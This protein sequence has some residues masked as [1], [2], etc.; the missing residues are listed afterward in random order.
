[1]IGFMKRTLITMPPSSLRR[2]Y[3]KMG[4][5]FLEGQ[6]VVSRENGAEVGVCSLC[7]R[8]DEFA[9]WLI[10]QVEAKVICISFDMVV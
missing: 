9:S 8:G 2:A 6:M 10:A 7:M 3:S 4:A 1:M 5:E